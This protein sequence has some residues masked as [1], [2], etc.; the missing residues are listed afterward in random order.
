MAWVKTVLAAAQ[1][2]GV[3]AGRLLATAG[4]PDEALARERWP[5]DDITRLWRAT[6]SCTGDP[7]FGLKAGAG[8]SLANMDMVGYA[9]QSAATLRKA[10]TVVQKY[11]SLISDGGR[12]QLLPG[13]HAS[14]LIYHPR[15]GKLP[16]SPYQIEAVLAAVV[17]I[18]RWVTGQTLRPL[19]VQFSQARLA[20]NREYREIFACPVEFDQAFSGFLADNDILDAPLPQADPGLARVHEQRNAARL[21][22]LSLDPMSIDQLQQ[23]LRTRMEARVP[24]RAEAAR[25]LGVS[26]R[27][28]A[29][30]L[31]EQGRT[32]QGLVDD[33]RREMALQAVSD[34]GRSLA[35]ITQSL[36]FADRSTFYRAFFRW[37]GMTPG[38]WRQPP[39]KAP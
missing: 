15:Q 37:T 13:E 9:M 10:I 3:D 4:L 19:R 8:V 39:T 25:A 6:E 18:A 12:F 27:T 35:D 33:I 36:G 11:Q 26:E 32:F 2:Q 20:S 28:L 17:T 38:E 31:G 16:F 14:W 23:W 34:P 5:I 24:R 29:R 7:A 30:R 21:T 1:R 22:E